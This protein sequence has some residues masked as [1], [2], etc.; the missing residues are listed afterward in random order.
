[1]LEDGLCG[2]RWND[3]VSQGAGASGR[4]VAGDLDLGEETLGPEHGS[5]LWLQ[6]LHRHLPVELLERFLP[7]PRHHRQLDVRRV[8]AV[9]LDP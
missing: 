7:L 8:P 2:G 4:S 5:Q 6:D 9:P 1:M 3:G